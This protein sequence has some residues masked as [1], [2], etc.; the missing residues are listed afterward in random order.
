MGR[1]VRFR[2]STADI[3]IRIEDALRRE[4]VGDEV[5]LPRLTLIQRLE[6]SS[7]NWACR[8]VDHVSPATEAAVRRAVTRVQLAFDIDWDDD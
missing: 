6:P 2:R 1:M 5:F 7:P 3:V 8:L 4:L